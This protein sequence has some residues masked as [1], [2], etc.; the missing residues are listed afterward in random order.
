MPE[1]LEIEQTNEKETPQAEP[2]WDSWTVEIPNEIIEALGLEKDSLAALTVVN[3]KIEGKV[4][5]P[6]EEIKEISKRVLEKNKEAYEELKK[7]GD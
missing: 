5:S 1:V 6:S 2:K 7:L 3:R 4:I